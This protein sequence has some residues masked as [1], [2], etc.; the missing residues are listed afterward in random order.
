M[1]SCFG[2][3]PENTKLRGTAL[4]S[5]K[6][7]LTDSLT[8]FDTKNIPTGKPVVMLY[9]GPRC[10]YSRAQTEELINNIDLLKNTN[11]YLLTTWPFVE[12]KKFYEH[13]KLN[14]Y[15]NITVGLDYENFFHDYFKAPGVPYMAIFNKTKKLN[16]A[17][18]G[19]IE[20]NKVL[21][22]AGR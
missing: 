22:V 6:L 11:I 17:F 13:Y 3:Q 5:F 2:K 8:Y 14:Q 18:V 7:L 21:E 4:P 16:D 10:A 19:E 20:S 9:F 12:M 15:K 1:V